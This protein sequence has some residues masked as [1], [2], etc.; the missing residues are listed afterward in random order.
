[1]AFELR[2][3]LARRYLGKT[4]TVKIDRPLGF[5]DESAQDALP[6][7][8]NYGYLPRSNGAEGHGPGVY[9]LGVKEPV[10]EYTA[11]II[12]VVHRYNDKEDQLVAAPV[13]LKL[14]QG[15]IAEAIA[16]R[17]RGNRI[18]VEAL[19]QRSCGVILYRRGP[20]GIEYLV[21]HQ[22]ASGIWSFP[23]GH[24]E[25][26]ETEEQAARRETMEEAGIAVR[27]LMGYRREMR[28]KMSG[29][30]EKT[31]ILFAA[32]TRAVPVLRRRREIDMF[33]FAPLWKAKRL[34]HPDYGPLLDELDAQLKKKPKN[35][36]GDPK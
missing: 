25:A 33:R 27:E 31:V 24:M 1:M 3:F 9:L 6:Y 22:A 32:Q 12:A 34:L 8:V 29:I 28:Y 7:P 5:V 14:H 21:L 4:V 35:N 17:E 11:R 10:C 16:F 15:E 18:S 30:I 36:S 13:G 26:G 23:K 19:Y 2:R 20:R